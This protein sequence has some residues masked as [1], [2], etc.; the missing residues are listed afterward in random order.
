MYQPHN[1]SWFI[2]CALLC[3]LGAV[4]TRLLS[5]RAKNKFEKV[6]GLFAFGF[7][8]FLL[9]TAG[10]KMYDDYRMRAELRKISAEKVSYFRLSNGKSSREIASPADISALM[11]RIRS[12]KNIWA[13]HS[14]PVDPFTIDFKYD[15]ESYEYEIGRDSERPDE[16]WINAVGRDEDIGRVHNSDLGQTLQ[17]LLTDNQ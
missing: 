8:L 10:V 16:Y 15:G 14:H 5:L 9:L 17:H 7:V 12:L 1:L 6:S 13:H 3:I 2:V 4:V 11:S